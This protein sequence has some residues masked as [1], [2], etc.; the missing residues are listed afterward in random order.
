MQTAHDRELDHFAQLRR[1]HC[2]RFG[3]VLGERQVGSIAMVVV[4]EEGA[5]QSSKMPP[6]DHDDVLQQL[7]P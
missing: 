1:L 5:Q 6:V 3:R 7:P 2:A 4:G